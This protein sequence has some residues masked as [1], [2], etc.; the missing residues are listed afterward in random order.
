MSED[1]ISVE[2][3]I[4]NGEQMTVD[5]EDVLREVDV[6]QFYLRGAIPGRKSDEASEDPNFDPI[7]DGTAPEGVVVDDETRVRIQEASVKRYARDPIYH[8]IIDGFCSFIIGK[9]FKVTAVDENPEVHEYLDEFL[10]INKFNGRDRQIIMKGLKT[11]EMFLRFSFKATVDGQ[12]KFAR[13]PVV[14]CLNFWEIRSIK[15]DSKDP[16]R[17]LEYERVYMDED[18]TEHVE[19]I[20][21]EEI[22]HLKLGEYESRRGL[23]PFRV[24]LPWCQ[25]Y[26]DWVFN[27][28]VLNRLKTSYYLDV[29]VKGSSAKVTSTAGQDTVQNKR[30]KSGNTILRMPKPGSKLVH[31]E[32]ITYTWL[33]PEVQADDAKEDGR[34]IRLHICAGG[35]VP[36]FLLGDASQANFASTLVSQNPFVRAVEQYQD[37]FG[38]FFVTV[39]EIVLDYAIKNGFLK[40]KSTET[41]AMECDGVI[42]RVRRMAVKLLRR[43]VPDIAAIQEQE[44]GTVIRDRVND[45]GD[46]VTTKVVDTKTEVVLGWPTLIAQDVLKDTQALQIQNSMGFVSLQTVRERL[47]YDNDEEQRRIEAEAERDGEQDNQSPDEDELQGEIDKLK[48]KKPAPGDAKPKGKKDKGGAED[49]GDEE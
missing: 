20:P 38:A 33:K 11:G 37:V 21:A 2:E 30:T 6:P 17:V 9:G 14:R 5:N 44:V 40:K 24:L 19:W 12:S 46:A 1:Q 34:V 3:R 26:G 49:Q 45:D 29:T 31:N 32:N 28:V 8:G 25:Y 43:H 7:R 39:F 42:Q 27:R 13:M 18:K 48:G 23:P 22:V 4:K 10:R 35:Q 15:V 16:E 36:E 47:G 41:V